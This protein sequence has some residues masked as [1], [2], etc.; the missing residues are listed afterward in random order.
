MRGSNIGPTTPYPP[1]AEV[2]YKKPTDS[3]KLIYLFRA[4][5]NKCKF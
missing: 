5:E 2:E 1:Q 4:I 3:Y